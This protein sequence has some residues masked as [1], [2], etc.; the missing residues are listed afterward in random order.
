MMQKRPLPPI[1]IN[2]NNSKSKQE[3]IGMV[4]DI[5]PS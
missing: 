4:G 1:T 3:T 2:N 5:K